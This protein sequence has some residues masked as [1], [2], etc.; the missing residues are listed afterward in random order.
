MSYKMNTKSKSDGI[1]DSAEIS[2]ARCC[3]RASV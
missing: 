2:L 3:M 1:K